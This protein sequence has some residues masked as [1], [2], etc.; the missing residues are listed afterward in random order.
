MT[1]KY[2]YTAYT[3]IHSWSNTA[4][5]PNYDPDI[6]G[7]PDPVTDVQTPNAKTGKEDTSTGTPKSVDH[8]AI[9]LI[10]NRPEHQPSEVLP[11]I[12]SNEHDNIEQQ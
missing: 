9:P 4:E 3:H 5:C 2:R 6:D 11:D 8:T 10:T 12:N 7:D 1:S